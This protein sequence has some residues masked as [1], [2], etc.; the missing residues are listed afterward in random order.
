M[1]TSNQ[2]PASCVVTFVASPDKFYVA[3][4]ELR[5][6][7]E[8]IAGSMWNEFVQA[9]PTPVKKLRQLTS[10]D[11]L[12]VYHK[13]RFWR[14]T[15]ASKDELSHEVIVFLVDRGKSVGVIDNN[16]IFPLALDHPLRDIDPLCVRAHLSDVVSASGS[17]WS[18]ESRDFFARNVRR[19]DLKAILRGRVEEREDG[20]LSMPLELLFT[21][22]FTETPFHP[23]RRIETTMSALLLRKGYA[24]VKDLVDVT[25]VPNGERELEKT[26]WVPPEK[27]PA[28]SRWLPP[29]IP[30]IPLTIEIEESLK[31][32]ISH[33]D[34]AFQLYGY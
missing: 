27:G 33:V 30:E 17:V 25:V 10:A 19:D 5:A 31:V 2:T 29:L 1:A 34:D 26:E 14:G 9:T 8:K 32:R 12:V 6:E 24:K 15:L 18:E 11:L 4:P 7:E 28:V 21:E 23:E 16:K 20:N 3:T 13:G 22:T